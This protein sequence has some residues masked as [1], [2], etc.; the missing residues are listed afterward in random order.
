MRRLWTVF[1]LTNPGDWL[2]LLAL[3]G[4]AGTMAGDS[5]GASAYA[6]AGVFALRL[7]P[8]TLLAPLADSVAGLAYSQRVAGIAQALLYLSLPIVSH[9]AWLYVATALIA[10]FALLDRHAWQRGDAAAGVPLFVLATLLNEAAGAL[11]GWFRSPVDLACVAAAAVLVVWAFLQPS[12]RTSA[13]ENPY[14]ALAEGASFVRRN[15]TLRRLTVGVGAVVAAIAVLFGVSFRYMLDLG[16]GPVAYG[17]MIGAGVLGVHLG[18]L[19]AP[20]LLVGL[21]RQR[22]FG[23][24]VTGVGVAVLAIGLIHQTVLAVLFA[25]VLGWFAAVTWVAGQALMEL[26]VGDAPR[27]F[28]LVRTVGRL[29]LAVLVPGAALLAGLIG[30]HRLTLPGDGTLAANGSALLPTGI[31]LL[32]LAAGLLLYR[33][34]DD[35]PGVPLRRDLR[36][37]THTEPRTVFAD[38]GL[39]VA[40]EGGEGVGKSTQVRRLANW[41]QLAGYEVLV[42]YQPGATELGNEIRQLLLHR[43]D[44]FVTAR[45]EALLFAADKAEHVDTMVRPALDRGTIVL[46]DRYVDSMLAYQGAGRQLGHEELRTVTDWATG[47]LRPHLTVLLDMEPED[48]LAR[49][50]GTG[51][52]DRVEREP[53]AFHRAVRREFLELAA[54]DQDRYAVVDA[55][56]DPDEVGARIRARVEPLLTRV[57]PKGAER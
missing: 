45:A 4:L 7:V 48:G 47:A 42:T 8:P 24:A 35:R 34:L 11:F 9:L 31:G 10:A 55:E 41:L 13:Y 20:R 30:P 36:A 23:L 18:D 14:D 12:H 21:P 15:R 16:A 1:G 37:F 19:V 2:G 53:T 54:A 29:E 49:A 28:G 46:T 51:E 52:A 56:Q 25:L 32:V 44:G 27:V 57:R 33:A 22:V 26:E 43:P 5:Y 39:F 50:N 40:F 17:M 38:R 6:I 3:V